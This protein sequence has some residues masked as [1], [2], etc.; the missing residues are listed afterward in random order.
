M[1]FADKLCLNNFWDVRKA[2]VM[3][4]TIN[5]FPALLAELLIGLKFSSLLVFILKFLQFQAHIAY[6]VKPFLNQLFL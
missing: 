5:V 6:D 4:N 2:L 1:V 3:Q